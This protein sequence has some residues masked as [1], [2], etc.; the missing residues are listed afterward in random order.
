MLRSSFVTLALLTSGGVAIA[1]QPVDAG[2]QLQQIPPAPTPPK[3]EPDIDI[4][5]RT[6]TPE[7]EAVGPKVRVDTLHVTGQTLFPEAS[8]IAASGFTPGSSLSLSDLRGI[9]ANISAY[10]N[11]RGYFLARAYLPPQ[12]IQDG[13]VTITVIEGQYGKIQVNNG[14]NLS[15]D[16]ARRVLDGLDA[17]NI[18]ASAPLERRLLLLS[19][20]P[21]VTVKSTLTPG[22][23]VG[24]SD[25]AIDLG[26]G[27]PITGSVE[28]DNAGN[29]YTGTYRVGGTVYFNNPTGIGD[30]VS[31][32]GLVSDSG[33]AY[34]RVA[35]QAPIGNLTV[36]ASYAHLRYDL[37]R[38][39]SGLD[40][41]GTADIASA[42]VSYPLIRSRDANLYALGNLDLK[43]FDD[44]ID[45][46][47]TESDK[48]S[49]VLTLG[50]IGDSRDNFSGGG[51]NSVS[52]SWSLGHLDLET[53]LDRAIDALTA[54]SDGGFNVLRF[55]A[56]RQQ[57]VS[58]PLSLYG[59]VRGQLPFDNL[60]S[61][62]KMELGGAYAVR[63]YP[64]GEAY[65]DQGYVATLEARL[66]LN[67]WTA[68]LPGQF[69]LIAFVDAGEVDYAHNPWFTGS[70]H[71]KRSGYGAG[72]NWFAPENFIVRA[73][74]AR[75]LGSADA[76]S[77]PDKSGRFWF[78][79]VK[80]F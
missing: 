41:D 53:P 72:L 10:Y 14:A 23:E 29:R 9:A 62:E 24:T 34:G 26:P 64:E 15:D 49:Q 13:A 1:Q 31:L 18:V 74:Y 33:L 47:S 6:V 45:L 25:L 2:A 80:L 32:R 42:Y 52:L 54:R 21:G 59:S 78:Q 58:G 57:T 5:P 51:W 16:V 4:A 77:A 20:I 73:S 75:K 22:T 48:K 39:F 71:A 19:D 37:G 67:Q 36:G 44:R 69:Q 66:M 79:I 55:A 11:K 56:A 63:A 8:L 12:D 60:D 50:L 28:A 61:S 46:F 40:A 17:G 27:R 70:N 35:Y 65:G 30:L 43:W 7:V 3:A 76:T 68:G 38:E